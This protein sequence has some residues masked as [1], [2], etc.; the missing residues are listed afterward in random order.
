MPP[1]SGGYYAEA[2]RVAQASRRHAAV[3]DICMYHSGGDTTGLGSTAA[4]SLADGD[5]GAAAQH[6]GREALQYICSL[7]RAEREQLLQQHGKA[8][9]S[10]FGLEI[11]VRSS[12]PRAT[13]RRWWHPAVPR[14]D[15]R[16]WHSAVPRMATP[17][18]HAPLAERVA[19]GA[20]CG[21]RP[22][23]AHRGT[24]GRGSNHQAVS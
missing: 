11:S 2:K 13:C 24:Y 3:V 9:I 23:F 7:E 17:L 4:G 22:Q 5:G 18:C 10:K 14:S 15:D 8:L 20:A 6:G 19:T 16:T 21:D 12:N 1:C